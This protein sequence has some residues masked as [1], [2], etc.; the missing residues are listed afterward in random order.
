NRRDHAYV[1]RECRAAV[2]RLF[3]TLGGKG[4]FLDNAMQRKFRDMYAM[5]GHFALNW[6]VAATTYGRVAMGLDPQ[7]HLK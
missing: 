2:D 5:S 1:V 3:T 4:I 7:T 6:D